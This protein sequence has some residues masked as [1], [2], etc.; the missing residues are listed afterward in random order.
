MEREHEQGDETEL[1][2]GRYFQVSR[3][4][5]GLLMLIS[6]SL[7][8]TVLEQILVMQLI[9]HNRHTGRICW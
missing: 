9:E 8:H 5:Q 7:L 2:V 4:G 1:N 6:Q 3:V